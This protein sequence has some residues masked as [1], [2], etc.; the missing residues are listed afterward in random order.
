MV[1]SRRFLCAAALG[2]VFALGLAGTALAAAAS[3]KW[4][5]TAPGAWNAESSWE[6]DATADHNTPVAGDTVIFDKNAVVSGLGNADIEVTEL[7][8][9][10]N[11]TLTL[12]KDTDNKSL[13]VKKLTVEAGKVAVVD[14]AGDD[15]KLVVDNGTDASPI[16]VGEDAQLTLRNK[17]I[18][19]RNTA[20]KNLVLTGKGTLVL[21]AQV[22]EIEDLKITEGGTLVVKVVDALPA[23][24][25]TSAAIGITKGTIKVE[26]QNLGN[27]TSVATSLTL[28][29]GD[30]WLNAAMDKYIK[31]VT[32]KKGKL[33]VADGATIGDGMDGEVAL[34]AAGQLVLSGD[35]T[36]KKLTTVDGS[37]IDIASGKVL[38]VKPDAAFEL[39]AEIDKGTLSLD[40]VAGQT[41]TLNK[42]VANVVF[43]GKSGGAPTLKL[44]DGISI[45]GLDIRGSATEPSKLYFEG[46]NTIGTLKFVRTTT[47][48]EV[49]YSNPVTVKK[50]VPADGATLDLMGDNTLTIEDGRPGAKWNVKIGNQQTDLEVRSAGLLA[51]EVEVTL[52]GGTLLLPDGA[53][54]NLTL[55]TASNAS[56]LEV[57]AAKGN[58]VLTVKDITLGADL[59]MKVPDAWGRA[60]KKDETLRLLKANAVT[61]NGH[62]VKGAP[63]VEPGGYWQVEEL[64]EANKELVLTA[65]KAFPV[66]ALEAKVESLGDERIVNVKVSGDVRVDS[67][68]WHSDMIQ[69]GEPKN[70]YKRPRP[71]EAT[72]KNATFSVVLPSDFTSGTLR[73]YAKHKDK[74][75]WGFVDVELKK[76]GGGGGGTPGTPGTPGMPGT[77]AGPSIE[78][79]SW[80]TTTIGTPDAQGNL[81]V[82]LAATLKL[83]GTP[84]SL[85]VVASGMSEKPKIELLDAGGKVVVSS[86]SSVI[87]A[88][89]KS[90]KLRLTCKTTK[91]NIDSGKA[92]IEKVLVTTGDGKVHTI[93]VNKKLKDIARPGGNPGNP[94]QPGNPGNPGQPGNPGNPGQPGNP[95]DSKGSS[96]GGCDAG[97]SGLALALV[98]AFLLRRKV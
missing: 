56:T 25:G 10:E 84:K 48:L 7:K 57:G 63:E 94:G 91:A 74:N 83:E 47:P 75:F 73:V 1:L 30:L 90:Y 93:T 51:G 77:P 36:L 82:Q 38:T 4:K 14:N 68:S 78:P 33:V 76:A 45:A 40:V 60:L 71:G 96:G 95:G 18:K 49:F 37:K 97:V 81:T 6:K 85:D 8:F 89:V 5:A 23:L 64:T 62:S 32:I 65:K 54:S 98:G 80:E 12:N 9:T 61:L 88:S 27:A 20:T 50:L 58:P 41:A 19:G 29:E 59:K 55:K 34:A 44:K 31:I 22:T 53:Y 52:A 39:N 87:G 2:A 11:A 46:S 24:T 43:K 69:G 28:D 67:N 42:N 35:L 16:E 72:E 15:E 79:S 21:E 86:M 17:K 92:T 70:N 13:T 66:P 3:F 26:N